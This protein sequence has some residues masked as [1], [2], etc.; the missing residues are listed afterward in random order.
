MIAVVDA[1]AA[2][3][4]VLGERHSDVARRIWDE[5]SY[6]VAPTIVLPEVAAAIAAAGR[7]HRIDEH[8]VVRARTAWRRLSASIG[9]RIVDETLS[10]AAGNIA[11]R[12]A[13]RGMDAIYLAVTS[14]LDG[15]DLDV[16]L[17]SFDH[18]QRDAARSEG[19][20]L[21]PAALVADVDTA[22]L[23]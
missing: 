17:L 9:L 13:T 12:G 2:V 16:A 3:K 14:E 15:R 1:S 21:M 23:T 6:A 8:G 20:N 18:R 4:L 22:T 10:V 19:M 11:E 5:V 7:M